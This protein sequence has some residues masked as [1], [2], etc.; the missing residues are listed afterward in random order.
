MGFI[1]EYPVLVQEILKQVRRDNRDGPVHA[2]YL[3]NFKTDL[4]LVT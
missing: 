1:E 3:A 4:P 2:R